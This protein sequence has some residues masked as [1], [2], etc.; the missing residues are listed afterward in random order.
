MSKT[1][2]SRTATIGSRQLFNVALTSFTT[3]F[4]TLTEQKY[5]K[6]AA[7]FNPNL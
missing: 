4:L 1:I 2:G 3:D 5:F 6:E 7:F